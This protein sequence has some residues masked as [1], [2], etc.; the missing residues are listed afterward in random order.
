MLRLQPFVT[1]L[2]LR[3]TRCISILKHTGLG[4]LLVSVSLAAVFY[5]RA[6]APT[7]VYAA[8]PSTLNFQARLLSASG[9]IVPDGSYNVEF[10]LY[11]SAGTNPS[12]QGVCSL[13]SST[14]DCW[15]IETR[16]GGNAVTVKGGYLTVNLGSVTGFGANVPWDQEL[17]LSMNI[18]GVGA[19][20]WDGEMLSVTSERL[21]L[22]AVPY[23]FQA[24]QADALTIAGGS[25]SG[26]SLAQ[27]AP[28]GLQLVNSANAGLRIN[29]TGAGGL[30][31]LQ[32]DGLDVLTVSKGGDITTAKGITLG[33]SSLANAG[34][35]RWSGTDFEGYDGSQWVSLTAGVGGGPSG[36]V[37]QQTIIKT[38]TETISA[39]ATLQDDDELTFAIGANEAWAF[40]FVVQGNS[41]TQPD[42][43]FAVTAPS[44]ASCTVGVVDG[45]GAVAV[46]NLGCGVTSG[47]IVGNGTNDVYEVA[48]SVTNGPTA[49]SVTL[50]WAQNS[51]N[52]ANTVVYA[53]SYV[54]ATGTSVGG[55]LEFLQGGNAFGST[56]VLGTT[57]NNGIS[58]NTNGLSRLTIASTGEVSTAGTLTVGTGLTISSG[59]FSVTGN[60]TL[61]G[62]LSGLTGLT[63]TSGGANITGGINLNASGITNAGALAGLTSLNGTGALT[64]TS[65]GGGDLSLSASSGVLVLDASTL[66][67]IAAGTT[68]LDLDDAANT[69]FEI[70][71]TNGSAVANLLVEGSIAA[72]TVSASNFSGNG[73]SLTSLNAA[74]ISSGTLD[75]GRLSSNIALLDGVQTFTG[76]P[77]FS[78][79][80][81]LG[82][83][84]LTGA[85]TLRWTGVD[86]E[87]Y[88]GTQ[89]LSLTSGGGGGSGSTGVVS[90]IKSGDQIVNN[91]STLADDSELKFAIEASE[92]WTFRFVVQANS[93]D[94]PDIQFA[95]TAPSGATCD[96]NVLDSEGATS[97]SNLGC[98][99]ASGLVA[100]NGTDD[101]YEIIG[102]IQNGTTAGMVQLRWSQNTADPSNTTVYAGS[103]LNAIPVIGG[104]AT[105]V[106]AFV[107][108]GNSFGSTAILGTTDT[109]E[110]RLITDGQNRLLISSGGDVAISNG[111]SLGG[112]LTGTGA[113]S[114]TSGASSDLTLGSDS[115]VVALTSGTTT[116]RRT[117]A[118][119]FTFDLADGGATTLTLDNSGAG[120]ASLNLSDG[121]L[122][123]AGTSIISNARLLSNL[124][125]ISSSGTVTFS[126][127]SAGGLV[128]ADGS[129]NLSLGVVGTDYEAGLTFNGGL[130]RTGNT[131]T[132]GGNLTAATDLGLNGNT[133][134]ISG[135]GG[136][137]FSAFAS[138]G[139]EI[140]ADSSA[141]LVVKSTSGNNFFSVDTSGNLVQIGSSTAD[142]V[143]IL[144]VLDSYNNATDPSG[145]NGA[146]YYNS[147]S[148]KFRCFQDGAWVDCIGTRQLRS[149]IDTTSDAAADNDTTDYWDMAIENNNSYPNLAP[150]TAT[151]VVTGSAVMEVSSG[152]TQDRSIVAH[153]ERGIGS[154][155]TC[156][157]GTV[158]G[159]RLSTFTTNS[160]EIATATIL[161][162]DAPATTSDVY[163]TLCADSATSAAGGM[164]INTIRITLEEANN[165]N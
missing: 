71:N 75:D 73:S 131:I 78:T 118:G 21:K 23:A 146:Q 126:S 138:G 128:K 135:S 37:N 147:Q 19:P 105:P 111:L 144:S 98:G 160:G 157:S 151:K 28:S 93:G 59:G 100:G 33:A 10:K 16:T 49:G 110:L 121:G 20:V 117:A 27:L 31:Q 129:G 8:S 127:L 163:Y 80:L 54:V 30:L 113:L 79:G 44:G 90:V 91:S 66:E 154:V 107:Q 7:R 162:V 1:R 101:T 6:G 67:R 119:V 70:R 104:S 38:V 92:E 132:L 164:T 41:A 4:V 42:F 14:D 17:W 24:A 99:I 45:E 56:A 84:A 88:D 114:I 40:R 35:L 122:Q 39:T 64:L 134:S 148:N 95:V 123:V 137:V 156:G 102:T 152:T 136:S 96:I 36:L 51:P 106:N 3:T 120:S 18:G 58:L 62:T 22:T 57:D 26:D 116:L 149:F 124:T 94:T 130:T 50:Q 55:G 72:N 83:T 77:T 15:W 85:G 142:A 141:A 48:G 97:M 13:D 12:S 158:V 155:P 11:D 115:G 112:N 46:G 89:W 52:A 9:G 61:S 43:Q 53:G 74:N 81:V 159:S 47:V 133:L 60:S 86:F 5:T 87:G 109:A 108:G 139:I 143:A 161:F 65:G 82:N 34:T 125:G 76:H 29:Q 145:T 2:K 68:Y 103:Y 32:G 69:T 63:V 165:S 150:S 140:R 153:I 25:V